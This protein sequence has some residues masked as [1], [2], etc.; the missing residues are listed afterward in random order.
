MLFYSPAYLSGFVLRCIQTTLVLEMMEHACPASLLWK[1]S[2]QDGMPRCSG[3]P[4]FHKA[5]GMQRHKVYDDV[6]KVLSLSFFVLSSE[7]K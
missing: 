5:P 3:R 1:I 2:G 6:D 4:P 7:E